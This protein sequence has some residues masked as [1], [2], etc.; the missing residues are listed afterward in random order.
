MTGTGTQADPYIITSWEEIEQLSNT[1]ENIWV[2]FDSKSITK[3]IDLAGHDITTIIT[4]TWHIIG[5]DWTIHGIDATVP[6]FKPE[7]AGITYISGLHFADFKITNSVF[8]NDSAVF[9]GDWDRGNV[10]W[11]DC[12]FAGILKTSR[13]TNTHWANSSWIRNVPMLDRCSLNIVCEGPS[14]FNDREVP[15]LKNSKLS[16][17]G[18]NLSAEIYGCKLEGVYSSVTVKGSGSVIDADISELS[19]NGGKILVNIDKCTV[20]SVFYEITSEQLS[21]SSYLESIKAIGCYV[22]SSGSQYIATG[23]SVTSGKIRIESRYEFNAVSS[24]EANLLGSFNNWP[25]S[26]G[27][28]AFGTDNSQNLRS[29]VSSGRDF[30]YAAAPVPE[31][32]RVY[33]AVVDISSSGQAIVV[34]DESYVGDG[35]AVGSAESIYIFCNGGELN[36]FASAKIYYLKIWDG[37]E[38]IADYTPAFRDGKAG[39]LNQVTGEFYSSSSGDL[40]YYNWY[41]D[42]GGE[43]TNALFPAV[44]GIDLWALDREHV[45]RVYDMHEPQDGFDGNGLAVLNPTVCTSLHNDERWDVELRHPLDDWG[46]W[47]NLLANNILKVDGQLFRIDISEPAIGESGREMYVHAK[48]IT[49]D[50]ADMLITF[51]TFPGGDA[52]RFMDFCFSSVFPA[53]LPGYEYYS[54]EGYS[55]IRTVL[56]PDELVNTSVW[57]AMVGA[58]NCLKNRYGGELY[59]DN[60]YFSINQRMQYAKD[61][62]FCLRYSLDMVKIQQRVDYSDVCTNLEC[63]DNFGN[64]WA[65]ATI[66]PTFALHHPIVRMVQFNYSEFEGAMERLAADGMAYWQTVNTPKVTYEAQIASLRRDPRYKDFVGLQNYNYGDSGTIYCPELDISTT[67]RITE[68]EK[69]ELTGDITRMLLGNLRESLSRPTYM[70]STISSGRSIEDKQNRANQNAIMSQSI[71]GMEQF[72]I[73]ALELRTIDQLE[74]Q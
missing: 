16:L 13:F 72:A 1:A 21:D 35:Y 4:N 52:A 59:R 47:K 5:N 31:A 24:S 20:P 46:K 29:V 54:F 44:G 71:S 8:V 69:D 66:A 55:D 26:S 39:V 27:L 25:S 43:L 2:A 33:T 48:H 14:H 42:S 19:G 63:Y 49:C 28:F 58:D 61:N 57:A 17:T 15:L 23:L 74:G 7:N 12:T 67:Q 51:A 53:D 10:K 6:I 41:L 73:S 30:R 3:S 64:Y 38:L 9:S 70:G 32:E 36:H 11:T 50:M 56:G 62:A 22:S 45:I 18:G 40:E 60:F 34:D 65:V 68:V 37:E